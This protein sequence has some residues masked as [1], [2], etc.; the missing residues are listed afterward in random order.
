MKKNKFFF[1]VIAMAVLF[2]ACQPDTEKTEYVVDFEDVT[3]TDS[4]WNGSD[5]SGAFVSNGFTFKNSYNAAWASWRGFSVS[6]KKNAVTRGWANEFSTIAGGGA[7][8]SKQF[9]LAFDTA[10]VVWDVKAGESFKAKSLMIT[11]STWA[12]WEIKEGGYGKVFSAGD[13]FKVKIAG[14]L[15]DVKTSELEY[16]LADFRDGK[17]FISNTWQK[18]SLSDLGNVNKIQFTFDSSDKSGIYINTPAYACI[19]NLV[20][21]KETDKE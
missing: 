10:V 20:I 19:D 17:S 13:W 4:I 15:N 14:Y 12:Y 1:A 11:N 6:A 7:S 8:S 21:E 2:T 5:G 9:G 16:Y 18:V 3:L